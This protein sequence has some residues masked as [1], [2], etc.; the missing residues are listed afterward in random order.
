MLPY[1]CKIS[2]WAVK[3]KVFSFVASAMTIMKR[4]SV[5]CG[6]AVWF[7]AVCL[8]FLFFL[9]RTTESKLFGR[10]HHTSIQAKE[11]NSLFVWTSWTDGILTSSGF[12]DTNNSI[13]AYELS[14]LFSYVIYMEHLLKNLLKTV[15][16]LLYTLFSI[17]Y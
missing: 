15:H 17:P 9:L 11:H 1:L 13:R 12:T 2:Q 6:E 10:L 3:K 8:K 7:K 5:G 14:I 16:V 4:W